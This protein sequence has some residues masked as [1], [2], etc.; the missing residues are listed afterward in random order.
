MNKI[1]V[2]IVSLLLTSCAPEQLIYR[3]TT[4]EGVF[5]CQDYTIGADT[6]ATETTYRVRL[7]KSITRLDVDRE[8]ITKSYSVESFYK[9]KAEKE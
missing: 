5:E 2:I 4:P 9:V 7:F 8:F 1:I 3:V 6:T